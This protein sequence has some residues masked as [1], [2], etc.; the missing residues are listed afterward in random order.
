MV[1]KMNT[2]SNKRRKSKTP[3]KSK[4]KKPCNRSMTGPS[5]SGLMPKPKIN[6]A[7][8]RSSLPPPIHQST[9]VVGRL[10]RYDSIHF[11]DQNP[12]FSAPTYPVYGENDDFQ[13]LQPANQRSSNQSANQRSSNESANQSS[14]NESANQRSSNQSANQSS[15]NQTNE[16]D[17]ESSSYHS[18][19]QNA[20]S[21]TSEHQFENPSTSH[22]GED[23]P[24][25]SDDSSNQ[26][27]S[28]N[29]FENQPEQ[30]NESILS[31]DTT[32]SSL[33][34][35]EKKKYKQF[36]KEALK[37]REQMNLVEKTK[38]LWF[39]HGKQ[40][41]DKRG[42]EIFRDYGRNR[43]NERGQPENI[44]KK[45]VQ[46]YL[47]DYYEENYND[48]F[49]RWGRFFRMV[50]PISQREIHTW[51][52]NLLATGCVDP[53]VI[54]KATSLPLRIEQPDAENP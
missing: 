34:E 29:L 3:N 45:K 31:T 15:N 28:E 1:R 7:V 12:V 33:T 18:A 49:T 47:L 19:N 41:G 52:K 20:S 46:D 48:L 38:I 26:N 50:C 9:P 44:K 13:E 5:T 16:F 23:Y 36:R 40:E 37:Q 22:D 32:I 54:E 35:A 2:K 8:P 42:R 11:A 39:V 51:E 4:A 24:T 43:K 17:N 53:L 10:N 14:S 27:N 30:S 6:P 21:L 25:S